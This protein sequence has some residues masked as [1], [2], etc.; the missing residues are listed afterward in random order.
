M[1]VTARIQAQFQPKDKCIAGNLAAPK[2]I[3]KFQYNKIRRMLKAA[4]EAPIHLI[5]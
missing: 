1:R 2:Q 4:D 5:T 3:G